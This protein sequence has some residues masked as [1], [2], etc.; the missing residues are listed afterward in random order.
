VEANLILHDNYNSVN[1]PKQLSRREL[2]AM[3]A[4]APFALAAL[5][6]P[7]PAAPADDPLTN[8]A[9]YLAQIQIPALEA[10]LAEARHELAQLTVRS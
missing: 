5:P 2:L 4:V 8:R 3:L 1:N 9:A 6:T 10:C 7:T